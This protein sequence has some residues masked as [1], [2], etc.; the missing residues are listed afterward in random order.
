LILTR[1]TLPNQYSDFDEEVFDVADKQGHDDDDDSPIYNIATDR[2]GDPT[3]DVYKSP[4]DGEA[5]YDTATDRTGDPL[6]S[7]Y[8]DQGE[9]IYS[10]ADLPDDNR[11]VIPKGEDGEDLYAVATDRT[12]DPLYE[13][14]ADMSVGDNE[15]TYAIATDRTGDPLYDTN[16]DMGVGDGDEENAYDVATDR[17]G[18]PLYAAANDVQANPTNRS[19]LPAI[20]EDP[21]DS[22]DV[23]VIVSTFSLYVLVFLR[24]V[25]SI[26]L[27]FAAAA[28]RSHRIRLLPSMLHLKRL[29]SRSECTSLR[30]FW[31]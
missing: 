11:I 25:D 27:L 16:E 2:T 22:K 10:T 21:A 3:Y 13:T 12:G 29:P 7:T 6:Y 23:Y 30:Y 5:V 18:D 26:F 31:S 24:S 15:N 4:E 9:A 20:S 28:T 19:A 8:G 14:N 17:T 1:T